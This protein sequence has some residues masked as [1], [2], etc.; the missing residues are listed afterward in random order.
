MEEYRNALS[1]AKDDIE[2]LE[3]LSWLGVNSLARI[4]DYVNYSH[5]LTRNDNERLSNQT[6]QEMYEFLNVKQQ[7]V[8]DKLDTRAKLIEYIAKL[9]N[10][11][12]P[13]SPV[14]ESPKSENPRFESGKAA[15][16]VKAESP[17]A[18]SGKAENL[19]EYDKCL[20]KASKKNMKLCPEGYCTAKAKYEVYPSAYA[21]AYASQVCNGSKPD[22]RGELKN[23]YGEEKNP[24]SGLT[25]WFKEEWVN[26]CEK[27]NKGK[28]KTCGRKKAD[29]NSDYPYCR[30]LNKLPNT[31]VKTVPEMS[32]KEINKMCKEKQSLEQG[33][34]NKPTRVY[35]K[36]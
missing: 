26:V 33:I 18:V 29:L 9:Y 7:K 16:A 36:K 20:E 3:I 1:L 17:K 2:K 34:D 19:T 6:D 28:Y 10:L 22:L 27:D 32:E 30:P 31:T 25:R 14:L 15:K 4:N 21:N 11:N 24:D 5:L 12:K 35:I 13:E 8:A 23:S